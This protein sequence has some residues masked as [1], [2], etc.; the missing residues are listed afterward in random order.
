MLLR[1]HNGA[2]GILIVATALISLCQSIL[3]QTNQN[4]GVAQS[5]SAPGVSFRIRTKD[6]NAKFRQGELITIEMLF[7]S[8]VPDVYQVNAM[9][10]DRSG[11]LRSDSYHIDPEVG[12]A[13]PTS[14]YFDSALF[15]F[16]GGGLSSL[17]PLLSEK[18]YVIAQDLNE[19][20]RFD[21]PGHYILYVTNKRISKVSFRGRTKVV[22]AIPATSNTI[23]LEILPADRAWQK[24]K[25]GEAVAILDDEKAQ[26]QR[27]ACRT[28]RFLNSEAAETEMIRRYRGGT[29]G[30]D[31][32]FHFGL[33]GSPRRDSIIHEMESEIDAPDHPI[34][35]SF[36]HT[37][38][39][40]TFLSEYTTPVPPN[41]A[42]DQEKIK[43]WQAELK[44]RRDAFQ[45]VVARY[46]RQAAAA[47]ARKEKPARAITVE[48]L[49]EFEAGLPAGRRTSESKVIADQVVAQLPGLFLDLPIEKQSSLLSS[50]FWK[51]I[52]DPGMLPV[53]RQIIEKPSEPRNSSTDL[54]SLAL[55]RL[56]ELAPEEGR[57]V[58][59]REMQ[60]FPLRVRPD[61]LT[62]LPDTTLP[63]LDDI[64]SATPSGHNPGNDFEVIAGYSRLIARYASSG[65][66]ARIETASADKIGIMACDIQSA[67]LAYF[68]RVDPDYGAS[69][70]E[71]ALAARKNT[72]CY[73]YEFDG[74][75]RLFMSPKLEEIAAGH[76]NDPDRNVAV[77]AATLLGRGS[78]AA[79]KQLWN[80]LEQ[81][82][83]Q[84]QGRDE[85]LQPRI[86]NGMVAGEP[87]QFEVELVR[88]LMNADAW[89]ADI[90]KLK[91]IEQLCLT[92]AGRGEVQAVLREWNNPAISVSFDSVDDTPQ[93]FA[94]CQYRFESLSKLKDKLAQFPRGS[95]FTWQSAAADP[96]SGEPLFQD[97]KGFL[98]ERGMTLEKPDK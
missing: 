76:L 69:A 91:K 60:R 83:T 72:G 51:R 48:T 93:S 21:R 89:I 58:I 43:L 41:P 66:L 1:S 87:A 79:E 63:E 46:A 53:L 90:D 65:P 54:R 29:N 64:L 45:E 78:A 3:G 13:D 74:V 27:S 75:G 4:A 34:T 97:L 33:I 9:T 40:L 32:E 98:E 14:E 39:V 86:E 44:K 42:G 77:Q 47:V 62:V 88:A 55:K 61:V 70:L 16:M 92:S 7:S 8:T 17:P 19:F 22:E 15:G 38:S 10:Y 12:V 24:Q 25:V 73:K 36:I 56:Y 11:R 85:E 68:L 49:L 59:L 84:W 37:L 30:C 50:F 71:Q 67:L 31:G 81:W 20:I 2:L 18:P 6:G 57:R 82:H 5:D 28:L 26:N 95:S 94:V 80:R 96:Q 23:D 52:A 35:S